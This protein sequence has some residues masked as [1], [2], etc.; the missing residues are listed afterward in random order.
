MDSYRIEDMTMVA[1]LRKGEATAAV[2][3]MKTRTRQ[4]RVEVAIALH[5]MDAEAAHLVLDFLHANIG[6]HKEQHE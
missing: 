1:A 6:E 2:R 5:P 3:S 4:G